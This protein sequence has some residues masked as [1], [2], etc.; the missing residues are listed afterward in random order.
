MRFEKGFHVYM[1][2][3]ISRVPEKQRNASGL[4]TSQGTKMTNVK[5]NFCWDLRD[6]GEP[7][8]WGRDLSRCTGSTI[9]SLHGPEEQDQRASG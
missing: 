1:E 5:L 9:I 3:I 7:P 4:G 6:E 8:G 2:K